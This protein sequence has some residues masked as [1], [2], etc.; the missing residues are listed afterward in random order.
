M[1]HPRPLMAEP[2]EAMAELEEAMAQPEEEMAPPQPKE[3][4]LVVGQA[5]IRFRAP[6]A[7]QRAVLATW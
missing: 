5:E 3:T 7:E 1:V 6:S 4:P 2:E